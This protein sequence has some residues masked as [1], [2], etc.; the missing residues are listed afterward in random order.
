MSGSQYSAWL[1]KNDIQKAAQ[2]SFKSLKKDLKVASYTNFIL[3]VLKLRKLRKAVGVDGNSWCSP[4]RTSKEEQSGSATLLTNLSSLL[5]QRRY[6]VPAG[7]V[8]LVTLGAIWYL[9]N[10]GTAWAVT[11]IPTACQSFFDLKFSWQCGKLIPQEYLVC[12]Y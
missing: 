7:F 11:D 9:E 3:L 12:P 4:D 8:L 2:I 1:Q 6:V 5:F 10:E